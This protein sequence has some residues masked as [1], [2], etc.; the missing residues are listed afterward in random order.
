MQVAMNLNN[1]T[2]PVAFKGKSADS[3]RRELDRE[4]LSWATLLQRFEKCV[5]IIDELDACTH[6]YR[7]RLEKGVCMDTE[8]VH[9][10]A[11]FD[12]CPKDA[13]RAQLPR[14]V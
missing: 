1:S 7:C 6:P 10:G 14:R 9:R 3:A 12:S 8:C 13:F 2:L 4:L 11:V 5:I